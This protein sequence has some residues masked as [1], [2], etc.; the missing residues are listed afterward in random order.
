MPRK[1]TPDR[2]EASAFATAL[3]IWSMGRRIPADLAAKLM[4]DRPGLEQHTHS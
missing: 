1:H 4:A 3:L 2:R